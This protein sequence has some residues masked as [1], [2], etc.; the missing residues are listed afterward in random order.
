M[1]ATRRSGTPRSSEISVRSVGSLLLLKQRHS[2][3]KMKRFCFSLVFP[4]LV[5][6]LWTLLAEKAQLL[7]NG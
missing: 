7:F 1:V 3:G 5:P 6:D 4:C 2:A